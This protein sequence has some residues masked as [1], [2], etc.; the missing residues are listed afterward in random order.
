MNYPST[1]AVVVHVNSVDELGGG[2]GAGR[3]RSLEEPLGHPGRGP[4]VVAAAAPLERV[5][6]GQGAE[7]EGGG[8]EGGRRDEGR[9][10]RW[11]P[12]R[13]RGARAGR[14][15]AQGAAPS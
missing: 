1:G 3:R 9:G 14:Q 4:D 8:G 12:A 13:R 7:G 10:G 2:T 15:A 6:R 5:P 11:V